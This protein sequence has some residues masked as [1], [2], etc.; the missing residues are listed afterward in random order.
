MAKNE[1]AVVE[2]ANLSRPG[3]KLS[4]RITPTERQVLTIEKNDGADKYSKTLYP[5]TGTVV[6]TKTTKPR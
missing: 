3:D 4:A 1:I 6:E 2:Q 5:T